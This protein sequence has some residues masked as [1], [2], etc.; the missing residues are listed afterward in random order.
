MALTGKKRIGQI[1]C[2]EGFLDQFQLK[3]AL[4]KQKKR[5]NRPLGLIMIDLGHITAEQL[6]EALLLQMKCQVAALE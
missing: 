6:R 4:E 3:E 1:L 2:E 5:K